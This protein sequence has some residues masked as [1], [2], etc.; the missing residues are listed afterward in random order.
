MKHF[1]TGSRPMVVPQSAEDQATRLLE[2]SWNG[3]LITG[4]NQAAYRSYIFPVMSPAG[5][6]VTAERSASDHPWHQSVTIG[7]DHFYTY[8]GRG[9]ERCEDP[10]IHFYWDWPFQGR[11]AGRIVSAAHDEVT[12]LDERH[13]RITQRLRWQSPEQ[14]GDPPFRRI[15]AE[16]IRT[17]HVYPGDTANVIDVRSQLRPTEWDLRL[18]PCRHAYFTIRVA[19]HLR[20][21]DKIGQKIG[22]TLTGAGRRVGEKELRWQLSDWIDYSGPD[23]RGRVAGVAVAQFPSMGNMPW[24][25][26]DYG[27]I[28][29]NAHRMAARCLKRGDTMDVAIRVIAHDGTP[30]E[31][32]VADLCT[33]LE[34]PGM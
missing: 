28:R 24:Y 21:T 30:V 15:L 14:W 17:I 26:V 32:G 8:Q 12:E 2:V 18:G 3:R 34:M 5:V 6:A 29:V 33:S 7:T 27:S 4:L 31:A 1:A 22:G 16:E 19:D 11:D 10:P 25:L 13:L 23:A 9:G 20:V